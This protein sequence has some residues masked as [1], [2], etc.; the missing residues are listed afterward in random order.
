MPFSFGEYLERRQG[1]DPEVRA[2]LAA[3]PMAMLTAQWWPQIMSCLVA[4][5]ADEARIDRVRRLFQEY[6]R[7]NAR[8]IDA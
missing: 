6:A 4:E 5:K 7:A 8:S 2:I 1:G 3:M